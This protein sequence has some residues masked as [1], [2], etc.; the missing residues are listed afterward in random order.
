MPRMGLAYAGAQRIDTGYMPTYPATGAFTLATWFRIPAGGTGVLMGCGKMPAGIFS[1]AQL[2][3]QATNKIRAYCKDDAAVVVN[4]TSIKTVLDN[5][6]HH[7]AGVFDALND[8]VKVIVDGMLDNSV[9][10]N[11]GT[12]TLDA[13]DFTVGCLHNEAG[14]T[15]YI[16]GDLT[17]PAIYTRE[18]CVPEVRNLMAGHPPLAGL[19]LFYPLKRIPIFGA[20]LLVNAATPGTY[21]GTLTG[22]PKVKP[23]PGLRAPWTTDKRI[24]HV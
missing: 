2:N 10:G 24:R 16:T 8:V 7:V 9:A 12:I 15:N 22:G 13:F 4:Q 14:Y 6:W 23:C 18:L 21:N 3:C 19:K 17:E 5:R 11:F 1:R 20:G